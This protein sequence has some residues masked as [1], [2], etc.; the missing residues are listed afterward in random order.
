MSARLL[1]HCAVI[2]EG[3]TVAHSEQL[4]FVQKLKAAFPDFFSAVRTLEI[5]S[6]DINGTIREFFDAGSY[7][8]IDVAPGPGVD[9]VC[10]GQDYDAPDASFDTVISC[11]VMEHNPHWTATFAN[12]IRL[13]R[14]GGL[15]VMTCASLGRKE[16]GTTRTSRADS[17]LT[18]A[19]GWEYYRNLTA[20][21]FKRALSLGDSLE[22]F[23]FFENWMTRDLYF[24][25]F[26]RGN[27]APANIRRTLATLQRYYR[28][29]NIR[30]GM[31]SD[32]LRTRL[33]IALF[34]EERFW[35]GPIRFRLGHRPPQ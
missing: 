25:G 31:Q 20:T 17:P 24:V 16:H 30:Y 14:P 5:G 10:Q 26:K 8:G 35:A 12:M 11:E 9:V 15:I 34:G 4:E 6:Q 32:Y 1:I 23:G 2:S 33:L 19:L 21:D 27:P 29:N 28:H 22:A 13:C 7:I 18:V 3:Y